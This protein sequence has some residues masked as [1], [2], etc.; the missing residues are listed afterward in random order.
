MTADHVLLHADDVLGALE[1]VQP[2]RDCTGGLGLV[3][4]LEGEQ[5][6]LW[7]AV[8]VHTTP[9]PV[10]AKPRTL[11]LVHSHPDG[12]YRRAAAGDRS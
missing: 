3:V 1:D 9:C 10:I 8:A 4:E 11:R 5:A 6:G 2:C 12:E 7:Y